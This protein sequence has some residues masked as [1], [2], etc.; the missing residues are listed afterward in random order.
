[1]ESKDEDGGICMGVLLKGVEGEGDGFYIL[2]VVYC[3]CLGDLV[4]V[5]FD[6]FDGNGNK[7][8]KINVEKIFVYFEYN[9]VNG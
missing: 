7:D 5:L 9:F 8:I 3:F 6:L 4:M 2:M 1:M